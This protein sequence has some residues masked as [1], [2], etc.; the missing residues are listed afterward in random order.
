MSIHN[1]DYEKQLKEAKAFYAKTLKTEIVSNDFL[2]ITTKT[3]DYN[4]FMIQLVM[5]G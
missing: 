3:N 1:F 4:V 2:K 5:F